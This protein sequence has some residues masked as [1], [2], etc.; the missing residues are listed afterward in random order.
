[1]SAVGNIAM[2]ET[3]ASTPAANPSAKVAQ[4]TGVRKNGKDWHQAKKA[5]RPTAGARE[6]QVKEIKATEKEMKAEKEE[7]RQVR[8]NLGCISAIC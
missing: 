4:V 3:L 1:M 5:F 6:S 2:A 8:G 7:E